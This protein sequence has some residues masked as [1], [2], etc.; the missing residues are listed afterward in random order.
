MPKEIY[1][2]TPITEV[3]TPQINRLIVEIN[4]VLSNL[5]D[6]IAK[7]EGRDG[8]TTSFSSDIDLNGKRIRNVGRTT[9]KTDAPSVEE[10]VERALYRLGDKHVTSMPIQAGG[11]ITTPRAVDGDEAVPLSQ[12]QDETSNLVVGPSS[13]TDNAVARF[14]GASGK[15][16]Q[17]SGVIIDDSNNML[18]PGEVEIDGDLDHDGSNIG[19]FGVALAP[20]AAAYTVTNG[21]TDRS[22]DA[23][24]TTMNELADVLATLIADLKTYGLLQ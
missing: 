5:S 6:Q 13:A 18:V 15:L 17:N 19:F 10:L 2:I 23:D 21:T 1:T 12:L 9:S 20:R 4:T 7:L 16:I 11:G 8:R 24:L 3:S 22:Y 14:D